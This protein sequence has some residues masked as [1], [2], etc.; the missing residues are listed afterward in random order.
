MSDHNFWRSEHVDM[1]S[2]DLAVD[3]ARR[4]IK[5]EAQGPGD[6]DPALARLEAKTGIGYWTLR[7]LWY[8]RRK[9][10][11]RDLFVRLRGAYLHL[12]ERKVTAIQTDLAF[13]QAR[14]GDDT[15]ADLAAEAEA[16]VAKIKAA[17][18]RGR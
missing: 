12:C 14:S 18:E 1:S 4:L 10:V 16:L 17:R 8:G 7:G 13:E 2:V 5:T 3:Y 15:F 6:F 9:L 11:D